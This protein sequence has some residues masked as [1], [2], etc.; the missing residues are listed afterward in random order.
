MMSAI[1]R[2]TQAAGLAVLGLGLVLALPTEG[3]AQ[4]ASDAKANSAKS[5]PAKSKAAKTKTT[6]AK[7]TKSKTTKAKT[8]KKTATS[9]PKSSA[10]KSPCKGLSSVACGVKGTTCS[11]VKAT[12]LK[13]GKTRKAHCRKKAVQKA[14]K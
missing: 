10:S 11:W 6:K 3:Q 14:K 7:T 1:K 13:T 2:T 9:K 4:R 12:K 8:A 5:K